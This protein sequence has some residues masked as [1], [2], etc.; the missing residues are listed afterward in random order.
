MTATPLV[1]DWARADSN[2]AESRSASRS[3]RAAAV[4]RNAKLT[5]A[6]AM[7]MIATTTSSSISVKPAAWR[8]DARSGAPRPLLPGADVRILALTPGLPIGPERHDID[9]ALHAG[10]EVLVGPPPGIRRQLVQVRLPVRR[11]GGCRG[12]GNQRLQSLFSG[13]IALVVEPVQLECLHQVVD[14]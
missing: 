12:P 2:S 11:D 3:S 4:S 13:G 6:L 5:P 10:V 14:V 8:R 9:L 7:A 1:R